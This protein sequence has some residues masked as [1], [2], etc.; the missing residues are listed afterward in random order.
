M[1][2]PVVA[3]M[4]VQPTLEK[5]TLWQTGDSDPACAARAGPARDQANGRDGLKEMFTHH[6]VP[7]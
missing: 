6:A 4:S 2:V 7:C 5:V 1:A 3:L